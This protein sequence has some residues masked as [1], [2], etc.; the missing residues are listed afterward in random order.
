[1]VGAF[2]DP[3]IK[4]LFRREGVVHKPGMADELLREMAPLLAEEGI[5]LDD[6]SSPVDIDTLNAALGRAVERKNLESATPLGE[7]RAHALTLLHLTSEAIDDGNVQL[8]E[9]MIQGIEPEPKDADHASVAHVIGVS[10]GLLDTWNRNPD[11][12][13]VF[14]GIRVPDWNKQAR[15]AATDI[16]ALARKGRAFDSTGPLVRQYPGFTVLEASILAVTG[17]LQAWAAHKNQ[18]VRDLGTTALH[19][20]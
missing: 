1:M 11:L 9:R 2:D 14:A 20:G 8:A 4:E 15:A 5:R 12:K 6:P 10:L 13:R 16:I 19:E 3:E 18:S 17:T 7:A